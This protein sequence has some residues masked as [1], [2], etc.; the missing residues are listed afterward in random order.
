M[1]VYAMG[2]KAPASLDVGQLV[3]VGSIDELYIHIGIDLHPT[4]RKE[5]L[6]WSRPGLEAVSKG[7]GDLY[8]SLSFLACGNLVIHAKDV[9]REVSENLASCLATNIVE[10]TRVICLQLYNSSPSYFPS[11]YHAISGLLATQKCLH[12]QVSFLGCLFEMKH[13]ILNFNLIFIFLCFHFDQTT[14]RM[15]RNGEEYLRVMRGNVRKLL[16][17]VYPRIEAVFKLLPNALS[18]GALGKDKLML[19]RLFNLDSLQQ[20]LAR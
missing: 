11:E 16:G 12:H 1:V 8:P 19:Q 6:M 17:S 2:Q 7:K 5:T 3:H 20:L 18:Q 15:T 14:A 9:K 10:G 4:D 13:H